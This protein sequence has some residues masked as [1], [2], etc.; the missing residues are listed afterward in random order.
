M[1]LGHDPQQR[2]RDRVVAAE[3]DEAG[4][5]RGE[6]ARP[7]LDLADRLEEVEGV[8]GDVARVGDLLQ[9]ER[10]HPESGL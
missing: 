5:G 1:A 6:F 4:T 8:A 10:R 3:D 9:R 2:E 7:G